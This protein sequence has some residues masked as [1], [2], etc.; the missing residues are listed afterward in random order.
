[1]DAKISQEEKSCQ[2]CRLLGARIKQLESQLDSMSQQFSQAVSHL[3]SN[4][5]VKE[6]AEHLDERFIEQCVRAKTETEIEL[7]RQSAIWAARV[8]KIKSEARDKNSELM[9]EVNRLRQKQAELTQE[10]KKQIDEVVKNAR[11]DAQKY[12][13]IITKL[14]AESSKQVES[15][16]LKTRQEYSTLSDKVKNL[17]QQNLNLRNEFQRRLGQATAELKQ[18]SQAWEQAT[19]QLMQKHR[20]EISEKDRQIAGI[21]EQFAELNDKVTAGEREKSRAQQLNQRLL[22]QCR[23]AKAGADV[24]IEMRTKQITD[25]V[26]KLKGQ[27]TSKL[28]A[29]AEQNT[30]LRSQTQQVITRLKDQADALNRASV[31][32][33]SL[34]QTLAEIKT[35]TVPSGGF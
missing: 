2:N 32:I 21:E 34:E 16:V 5:R 24:E 9:R 27:A 18:K 23:M 7:N 31:R 26:S 12:E 6:R 19:K 14:K 35:V 10:Y 17:E 8:E 25:N 30:K 22:E 20:Q 1:M 33:K 15:A 3:A 29:Y 28:R 4:K 11:L 13:Q